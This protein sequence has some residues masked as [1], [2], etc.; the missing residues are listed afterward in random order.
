[1]RKYLA[2]F[3]VV[4]IL[5]AVSGCTGEGTV[6][7][8][9][10]STTKAPSA[11]PEE[12]ETLVPNNIPK[13]VINN[14]IFK[15]T[16]ECLEYAQKTDPVTLTI[17]YNNV[18]S[19]PWSWGKDEVTAEIQKLTGVTL[20]GTYATDKEGSQL[21]LMIASGDKLPDII[22]DISRSSNHLN[23][24]ITGEL[25]YPVNQLIDEYCPKMWDVLFPIEKTYYNDE[26]GNLW[27]LGRQQIIPNLEDYTIANGWYAIRKDVYEGLGSPELSKPGDIWE[28]LA[29][30]K[31]NKAD[32]PE[33]TYPW[34]DPVLYGEGNIS[35]A[36]AMFG[37][38][39]QYSTGSYFCYDKDTENV[40]TVVDTK[41]GKKALKFYY[42]LAQAG[43]ITQQSFALEN[44]LDELSAG[45]ALVYA[46]MN[47]WELGAANPNLAQNL[48]GASYERILPI[49]E[50]GVD[51][52]YYDAVFRPA[53]GATVITKD[54]SDPERAILF[55][56]FMATEYANLI[57]NCGV[58]GKHWEYST[59]SNGKTG[60]KYIGEAATDIKTRTEL[61]INNYN[62]IWWNM[63]TNYNLF[64]GFLD[65][66]NDPA[67]IEISGYVERNT[68]VT[69][70]NFV[71][72]SAD[73][74]ESILDKRIK[75][76][77]G[78]YVTKIILASNEDKFNGL[79]DE[80]INALY[81]SGLETLQDAYA[82]LSK[83]F[84]GKLTE[85]GVK[86]VN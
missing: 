3:L 75:E 12:T 74:D 31:E 63:T 23:E 6:S 7:S 46:K 29:K 9:S 59:Y 55:F 37:G 78:T 64:T 80:M 60:I 4:M 81:N 42:D 33:I 68:A 53:T 43:Y 40:Y 76:I 62:K 8:T 50:E 34:L 38:I 69:A 25:V 77:I 2:F 35:V 73:S 22:T 45:K 58:Y 41:L 20:K 19:E 54:C 84:V 70:P 56:E 24:L 16:P 48:P 71:S 52:H 44:T 21:T 18:I 67:R 14:V 47:V 36:Y 1:M 28:Y 51:Y 85:S 17:Y 39:A 82:Q 32:Y 27:Y 79:Y 65:I 72:L 86:W 61:G 57:A 30:Y 5:V 49:Y 15:E 10:G 66:D 83:E 26:E 11:K 13:E